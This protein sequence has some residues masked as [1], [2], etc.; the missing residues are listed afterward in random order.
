MVVGSIPTCPAKQERV[1][2]ANTEGAP[3]WAPSDDNAGDNFGRIRAR[4][5]VVN[6]RSTAPP[7]GAVGRRPRRPVLQEQDAPVQYPRR[8]Q[9]EARV[10][11]PLE[12]RPRLRL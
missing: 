12:R 2:D 8:E 1:I 3:R 10:R 11:Q 6:V 5:A 7:P 4:S 9:V